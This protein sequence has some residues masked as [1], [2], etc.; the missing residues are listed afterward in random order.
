MQDIPY[1]LN[2]LHAISEHAVSGGGVEGVAVVASVSDSFTS[3]ALVRH[4]GPSRGKGFALL[5]VWEA[6]VGV[7]QIIGGAGAGQGW[8]AGSLF[9]VG[10]ASTQRR[11]FLAQL[12]GGLIRGAHTTFPWFFEI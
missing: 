9:V 3:V 4:T 5:V 12:S 7:E 2:V 6:Q 10:H 8:N 1:S 11:R